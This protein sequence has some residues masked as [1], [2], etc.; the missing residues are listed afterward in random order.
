[1]SPDQKFLE[2][3]EKKSVKEIFFFTDIDEC[4]ASPS[5]CDTK[6]HCQNTVGSYRCACKTGFFGNGKT[7]ERKSLWILRETTSLWRKRKTKK[8]PDGQVDRQKD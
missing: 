6:A 4:T 3:S 5:V 2:E 1:M 8:G 7:Y